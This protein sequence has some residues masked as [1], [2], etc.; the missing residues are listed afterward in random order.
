MNDKFQKLYSYLKNNNLT[1]LDENTF[2]NK[3]SDPNKSKE[4]HS[5]LKQNNMTDLDASSF[6]SSYFGTPKKK[7]PSVSPS[8][9]KKEESSLDIFSKL[10]E[11]PSAAS[12]SKPEGVY[13]FPGRKDA[14]Y[15]KTSDKWYIDPNNSGKFVEITNKDRINLLEKKSK[16]SF[17]SKVDDE[18]IQ[19]QQ[20]SVAPKTKLT[21]EQKKQQE[22]FKDD[23]SAKSINDPEVIA[24]NKKDKFVD[25]Q[26]NN[27][28][29]S[30]VGMSEE[31]AVPKLKE[32][33]K[34][35]GPDANMFSFEETGVGYDA[36]KIKNKL[37]GEEKLINLDNWSNE[38]DNE[39]SKLLKAFLDVNLKFSDL[40]KLK[41]QAKELESQKETANAA[42]LAI[43]NQKLL[44]VNQDIDNQT[45]L[46]NN[47]AE[48]DKYKSAAVFD[49][50]A[51][52]NINEKFKRFQ[53][54]SIDVREKYKNLNSWKNEADQA[55]KDGRITQDQYD[56]QYLPKIQQEEQSISS[57]A[58]KIKEDV[59]ALK[60]TSND[61]DIIAGQNYKFQENRGNILTGAARSALTGAGSV[62]EFTLGTLMKK[63]GEAN[64]T[65][66]PGEETY[67][68]L[69]ASTLGPEMVSKEYLSSEKR[70]IFENVING[71]SNSLGSAAAGTLIVP[72]LGSTYG[73]YASSYM[74][75]RNQLDTPEMKDVPEYEKILLSSVYG[76]SIGLLEKYGLS[77]AFSKS[78][79]G[80]KF[81]N[82]VIGKSFSSISKKASSEV[83]ENAIEN[84]IK[85]AIKKGI[86]NTVGGGFIEG[87]T[88]AA[89]ELADVGIKWTYNQIKDKEYFDTP[90]TGAE[91]MGRLGENF[92]LGMIGGAGMA[93][94]SQS[95]RVP[96][97][98]MTI[99]DLNRIENTIVDENLKDIFKTS[100]KSQV[101][102]EEITKDQAK[103]QLDKMSKMESIL[104]RIPKTM[105]AQNKYESFKLLT[106]KDQLEKEIAG[107]DENLTSAQRSRI[108]EINNQLSK[109]S[110]NAVKESTEQQQEVTA[111]GGGVQ[112][113]GVNEGQQEVGQGEGTVRETAQPSTDLGN[114]PVESR[115]VE[116][117][118]TIDKPVISQN[119]TT[120]V[121][122][123]KSVAPES[124]DGATFNL[125]GTKYE[126]TG[127]VVPVVSENTTAEELTP[128]MIADF[129]EK[130]QDKIGDNETVKV[131]I[132]KFPNSNKISID[133][134][135]VAPE[136]SREQAI[137]FGKK[138]DQESLF[139][140][141]TF[142]NVK[143]GGTGQNP[144]AFSGE[145]FKEIAKAFKEGR[146]P[147]V[148]E[149]VVTPEQEAEQIGLLMFGTDSEID[150]KAATITN[151][152]ISKSVS[153][154]A[155]AVSKILPKVKFVVHDNDESYRKAT[156]EE[157]R[158]QSSMGEYN[159]Q[160]K[161]IHIN[162]SKANNRT[163]AHEVFHAVLLDRV[164]SDKEAASVTQRMIN[165][166]SGKIAADSDLK[167]Y[168]D[169]FA[170]NYEEN[171]QNEEKLAELVG[172]LSENYQTQPQTIKDI[173]KRWVN[174]LAQMFGLSPVTSET[175]VIE[176]LDTIARKVATGKK[177]KERQVANI[178]GKS[179]SIRSINKRFQADFSDAVSKL[180]FV[181]D[182]NGSQFKKLENDGFITR[183][184]SLS[185]FN[186][187]YIFLHQPDA[188]FSGIIFKDGEILVEGK[189]GVFYPIKFHEDGYF[190]ASTDR[191]AKKMADDLNKVMEQ[192]G[193]TI[194]MA[195]TSAPS[196]KLMSST[197]MSNAIID[198]FSSKA[199]DKNFKIT[200]AQLKSALRKA[201]N[202]I[203]TV[204]NKKVG[205]GL[206]LPATAT[207]EDMQS[208]IRTALGSE[209]SSFADRKNFAMELTR[210]MSG[211]I[212]KNEVAVNQFG[213][214]F[215]EGIQNKYFKGITKT[216]K[217]KISATNMTQALSE[218]FTEPMLK[219][220]I[221]RDKGGQVYAILE[222]NGP[223]KAVKSDKHESYP[224]AIESEN[225]NN[226][227]TLHLLND[228]QNWYDT[229]E[230]FETGDIVSKER[231]LK[232]FPTSGVSVQ[233]LK[234]N[235]SKI[236]E[237]PSNR[238]QIEFQTRRQEPVAGNKLFNEPLKDAT[239]IADR[240]AKKSGIEMQEV[241]PVRSLDEENSKA[242][243]KEFDKMKNDPTNPEVAK[244]YQAMADETL[245]QY[246]EIIKD[247]YFV[248]INNEEPYSSSGDMINDLNQNKRMK[249]FSTES[250]F[251]YEPI[252]DQQR[253]ENPLLRD[254]GFKDVNGQ[255]LLVNDVFRFVHDFFG[256]AKMGNSFGPIGEENAWLI[257]S[258][259]YS[260]LARRAMT[261]ETRGQNS[262]VNFSGVNEEAFKLRDKAR[263]LRKEGKIDEANE[264]V[265]QVYDKMSFAEQKVGLMPEWVSGT[266]DLNAAMKTRKQ[267]SFTINDIVK[268]AKENNFS[269]AGIR[270]YLKQQGYS[271]KQSTEAINEYNIKKEDI[272]IAKKG[273]K[274]QSISSS[275]ASFR[276]RLFSARSFLPKSVFRYK[277]IKEA[278]IAKNLNIVDQNVTDFNRLYDKY[279]GDQEQL[280]KDFD[281]Y[282]R[283]DKEVKLPDDFRLIADSMR[284]QIDGLSRQLID[285][286]LVDADMAQTIKD[287]LGQYLTRSYK[288][289]D[290]ENWKKEVEDDIKQKAINFL[291]SQY[292]GMAEEM[293]Q[294]EDMPVE[295]VLDNLVN[296]KMDEILTTEGASNFIKG[297][298]LGAK[299]LSVLK[300]RQDIPFEI[301]A[302]MGE[303][304]DPAL[305]YAKTVLKL[306]SLAANHKFLTEVKKSGMGVYLFEKNDP[307]RPADFNTMIASEGSKG[308]N[309]LNGLYTTKEIAQAFEA[310]PSQLS[311]FMKLFMKFQSSIRW[312]KTIGSIAT[313]MKNVIGNVGF[314][315]I[316]GH[317]DPKEITS[318]YKTAKNDFSKKNKSELRDKMNEY[319]SLGIVKQSAGIGEIMDMFKDADWDTAMAS[320]LSNKKIG[321]LGKAKRFLLQGKKK[322]ED[323]Y[324]A[325]DDFFK[326]IAYENE[327]SRYSKAMFGKSKNELTREELDQ[328]NDV[329]SE[330]VKNTYPTYDRIPE[331]VKMIRRAPFIGNFVSFQA[332]SYRTAFNTMALAKQELTSDNEKIRT[333]GAQRLA[334]AT[335]Y[336]S[337]KTAI[338]Q[339]FSM[340]AGTGLTG[341]LGYLFDDDDEEE[342][343]KDIRN[344]IAPW[345][346]ESD[347]LVL[348]VGDGKLK[349]IDFS[350]SDPHGGIKKAM[351]AFLLGGSTTD[352]FIDGIVS[353][354]SPF[355]GEEMTTEALLELKNNQD[356]YGKQIWNP[357]ESASEISQK[358]LSHVYKLVEPGTVS[359]IRRG[360]ESE[361]KGRELVANVTGFRTYDVDISE[362]FGFKMRDYSDRIKDAKRIYNSSFYKE[363]AT[364]K[365]KEDAYNKANKALKGIYK[366]ITDLYNSAE[367]LGAKKE[368]LEN[369]MKD[370]GGIAK[371][372]IEEIR[373]GKIEDL[374]K[375]EEE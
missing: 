227:V 87:S 140:L 236:T 249:I 317:F 337:A 261:S 168:L 178:L 63:P 151:K 62:I 281:S 226:K 36:I 81:V 144:M 42:D 141:G 278:E 245:A 155:K 217:L 142:E 194:Y 325:E 13:T 341:V 260:P 160:T 73:L 212:N 93:A 231:Q 220:G 304:S 273:T 26:L 340:A 324:Q 106:E 34:S 179:E 276:K 76:A 188:A 125:D 67:G 88:E 314:V 345:S 171:I 186:G 219:E 232:V 343:E 308:M 77:K 358:I 71:L 370:F 352:K 83:I 321:L 146:V 242:I 367:R 190:W 135:V 288:I 282:I 335:T 70:N 318:A 298:K 256:H 72:G 334:G 103:E 333:I 271:D 351:N 185:D 315:W 162:A 362:Q 374:K 218:M 208:A 79:M 104:N 44:K 303:Y 240:Y 223:V 375:K 295:E 3:Y 323:A 129:V 349:Y 10:M 248:E 306:S 197:T 293:A 18:E 277:E 322:L 177:I 203:K 133:L 59:N 121:E 360:W 257:H 55:L 202:D 369:K 365:E 156:G 215:S 74:S 355:I 184:K 136:Q 128:E 148:F 35:L 161:T 319:I 84:N 33:I 123:V 113:Q 124:E 182:K 41:A 251:G 211:E 193:G 131:G 111:E 209:N 61:L 361:N 230:D 12:G 284:N 166:I 11:Q 20:A 244:A 239:T 204:N 80:S 366:E 187:K 213:K 258:A 97:E 132:Y 9:P 274:I 224:M 254:S 363:D 47:Y 38:R 158:S 189:G 91:L 300:E 192:N 297:S 262:W 214:L 346:K 364:N 139:D 174:K 268:K 154:A 285:N 373:L 183:D 7:E 255:T 241:E 344:F 305:N 29:S 252:T 286:G 78:P 216:G 99:N 291:R 24:K 126:G 2:Y 210:I 165:A 4:I 312:A 301:R 120:E 109:I 180:T 134:N 116:E 357:E 69:F 54:E 198:F 45:Q 127:L 338:L 176:L 17:N 117:K 246:E 152:S 39:E 101:L 173:I 64:V 137:E 170:S 205:L 353:T 147:N 110:E 114:R 336:L 331:A 150:Q 235:T 332:E 247:G 307:R 313:H 191:T 25:N 354:V 342:R 237:E 92:A 164:T 279:K 299:D 263:E 27:I 327:L 253:K 60:Y 48:D 269:D 98:Q 356:K 90:K 206:K 207:I 56:N 310:Q 229:F 264:L 289:Y 292:R 30:L 195:L 265:G 316:N 330:I 68:E 149:E 294:K 272:W 105:N 296:N 37:T 221:D 372:K 82:Y 145:Q 118:V 65:Y 163:I 311:D 199:F 50:N 16:R 102:N 250:G 238:K 5:Y 302:L 320:R 95:L 259:M 75:M 28:N 169:D 32:I 153:K 368:D 339:Y 287:N 89:Q 175:E 328:V 309:P 31:E 122:R 138:A 359:S 40:G 329:V 172:K 157:G 283:G 326:I 108:T 181:F 280:L 243:A 267:K 100:L 57:Q 371:Y 6:H 225:K 53:I 86:V 266:G 1:D 49:K 234:V 196:D 43:I 22:I 228:R 143:T 85:Q 222:L 200:P 115:G 23:F 21:E 167:K 112:Y 46:R 58:E 201:A 159:P 94:V 19:W 350:A 270:E 96:S 275:I 66:A 348:E 290:R 347:L 15:K 52:N 119:T 130:N 233:G 14:L 51:I 107:Y 8:K